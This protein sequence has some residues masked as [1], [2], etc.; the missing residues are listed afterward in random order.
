MV[1]STHVDQTTRWIELNRR[2]YG[3]HYHGL[4]FP[5]SGQIP[6]HN[7][8]RNALLT[9]LL[10]MT[11]LG[12]GG[13]KLDMRNLSPGCRLCIDGDWSCLFI[14]GRCNARCF[15]CPSRQDETGLPTTNSVSFRSPLDYVAY[16]EQF[17][18]RGMSLSGGEPLLTP[19]RSLAFLA[20]AKK[21]FGDQLHT[22]LYTNG[23]LVNKDILLRLRDA[24]LDEIRFDIGAVNYHLKKARLAV[25]AIPTVT[26][27]IPAVPEDFEL[28]KA[29]MGEMADAGINH[30]NLHQLRLTPYSLHRF[31][32]RPYTY[33]HGD[34]V[35]VL[36]SELT[37][38]ALIKHGLDQGIDLPVNYCSFVYKNRYQKAAALRRSAH[39]MRKSYETV[40]PA[41]Y[42]RTLSVNGESSR[43]TSLADR[44]KAS[45]R[46]ELFA[47]QAGRQRLLLSPELLPEVDMSDLKLIVTYS[48]CAIMERATGRNQ[49]KELLLPSRRKVVVERTVIDEVEVGCEDMQLFIEHYVLHLNDHIPPRSGLCARAHRY[50]CIVEG[51]QEYF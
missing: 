35:T 39:C 9:A 38:L 50:E 24:G 20:A 33:L 25:G 6:I 11:D 27:E 42:L 28:L 5:E 31:V 19:G 40:T 23:T 10:E 15:Y 29:K 22:W 30:L 37:A 4:S 47:L 48:E 13:T 2:E 49:F 8:H 32:T 1:V 3:D 43:L 41:G 7:A 17:G 44:F 12:C 45:G 51:L 14:N 26:V 16:L 36:E 46:D 18:F 21:R 34:K